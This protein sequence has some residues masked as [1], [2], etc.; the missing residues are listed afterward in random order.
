MVLKILSSCS[1]LCILLGFKE[2]IIQIMHIITSMLSI[3]YAGRVTVYS[4][5][6]IFG[7]NS[8]ILYGC[9]ET[10]GA[11]EDTKTLTQSLH[12]TIPE[13]LSS[14][15]IHLTL[16]LVCILQPAILYVLRIFFV[17]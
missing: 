9:T 2:N 3:Q 10:A 14:L 5:C 13:N 16:Y 12:H 8:A 4:Y 11:K 1:L 15:S 17:L 7:P 6:T